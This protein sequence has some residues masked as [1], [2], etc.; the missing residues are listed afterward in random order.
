ME[1]QLQYSNAGRELAQ[2]RDRTLPEAAEAQ[3]ALRQAAYKDGVLSS[4]V[5]R[6]VSL[7]VALGAQ[8][9]G[10]ILGQ[11]RRA[12]AAGATREEIFEVI[13]VLMSMRGT[14]GGWE[15]L[16]VIKLLNEIEAEQS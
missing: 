1:S 12:L 2:I 3:E 13:G 11:T 14:T 10:C 15:S 9:H 4:K 16:Q 7:G 5:K 6:L 8:C